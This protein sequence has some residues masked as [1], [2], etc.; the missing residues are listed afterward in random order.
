MK[1]VI[2]GK[3]IETNSGKTILQ[4][5]KENDI[6]IPSLCDHSRLIPFGGCRLCLV[7]IKGRKG[8]VPSC[9]ISVDDGMQVK[10][11]TP[12]L[13]KIR[14]E[15]LGLILTEHPDACLICS[16]KENCDEHKSTI[17][18]VG[19]VT[20]CVLCPNNGRCE[21]QETVDAVKI[22]SVDFPSVYRDLEIVKTD[23]F[24]ERN[25]N[26]CILC[27]RCVRV[28]D[29]I[30][31]AS[32][33]IFAYRGSQTVVETVLHKPLLEAGCQFCGACVDVCP[34][35]ALTEKALKYESLPQE[36]TKTIC[37]FCSLGCELDVKLKDGKILSTVPSEKGPVNMGQ[38]C[39]KGRF[40][41]RDVVYSPKRILKPLIRIKKKLEEVSWEEALD[42]VARNI[43]K[44]GGEEIGVIASPHISCE[45]NYLLY[46]F[47]NEG[48]KTKNVSSTAS[49][50]PLTAFGN[51]DR[52]NG[53]KP[54]MNF[55]GE[56]ISEAEVLFLTGTDLS[57]SHPILW[58]EV[59]KAIRNGAKLIVAS[60]VESIATRFA[61]LWLRTNP[62]TEAHLLGMLSKLILEK[63]QKEE[64]AKK[65]GFRMLMGFL[66][67]FNM[68]QVVEG[69]GIEKAQILE[70]AE[71]ILEGKPYFLVGMGFTQ[72]PW[73]SQ[74]AASLWN[75]A[76]LTEGRIIPLSSENNLRGLLE[77]EH[78][79]GA[80]KL[81]CA[82]ILT[83]ADKGNVKALYLV[84]SVLFPKKTKVDFLVVQDSFMNESAEQADAVLPA[85][86]FA[87]SSGTFINA[88]GRVLKFRKVIEPLGEAKPDSWI[89][90]QLAALWGL[91]Q[92]DYKSNED[93]LTDM[94][95]AVPAF[96]K[97]SKQGIDK[98][99]GCFIEESIK[100]EKKFF[101][102]DSPSIPVKRS[103]NYP[104]KLFADYSQ[105]SYRN[106]ILSREI[107]GLELMRN[108]RWFRINPDDAERSGFRDGDTAIV[109]TSSGKVKGVIKISSSVPPGTVVASFFWNEDPDFSVA[110]LVGARSP[111]SYALEYLPVR[112]KRGK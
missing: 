92:F 81:N 19:E 15:I 14:K 7:E 84:G 5:A 111:E 34:T 87:E 21:L 9:S 48:L 51:L 65:K 24:F 32:T 90:S 10:T 78:H 55:K 109:E 27:G 66:K 50:S 100:K 64:S 83:D 3:H 33:V 73:A 106:L 36:S 103:Q 62:G 4:A 107:R 71:L 29:E 96:G 60:P 47:V 77:L 61:S 69:T 54:E 88:E 8:Y 31:G 42:F 13:R 56:E 17:R 46:R 6:F 86:T 110:R 26:L 98:A 53:S 57:V 80:G 44:F 89:I 37:P 82:Q 40:A 20:G 59:L 72:Y 104:F 101:P 58:L 108:A 25:Y 23:P 16:E 102:V 67:K 105:D 18:K 30:R 12:G 35:G 91:K 97:V 1:I 38:A 76:L 93:I 112:I 99:E 2:D 94:R 75:L 63:F 45:E 22:S 52:E 79:F 95:K 43:K 49:Y 11:N 70:A 28:C 39:V 85:T 68:T 74:N 41:V